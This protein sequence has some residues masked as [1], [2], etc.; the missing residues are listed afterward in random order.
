MLFLTTASGC[1]ASTAAANTPRARESIDI[2]HNTGLL[3]PASD[4]TGQGRNKERTR[5]MNSWVLLNRSSLRG[6]KKDWKIGIS[7]SEWVSTKNWCKNRMQPWLHV[8]FPLKWMNN[9]FNVSVSAPQKVHSKS[10]L[11]GLI[12]SSFE[13][14]S[15]LRK[16]K[17]NLTKT[18]CNTFLYDALVCNILV[19][20]EKVLT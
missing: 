1:T 18:K 20:F 10:D 2:L 3:L 13:S 7:S 12:G 4:R 9:S 6:R 5:A 14:Y 17:I 16:L 8:P 19:L 15:F 11:C